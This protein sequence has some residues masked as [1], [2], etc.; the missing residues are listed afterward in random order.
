MKSL[1]AG[2]GLPKAIGLYIDE[3]TVHL[4][5]VVSTPWGPVEVAR[6]SHTASPAAGGNSSPA[7]GGTAARSVVRGLPWAHWRRETGICCI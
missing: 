6:D 4:S 1:L 5:Q 7:A 2:I 3:G